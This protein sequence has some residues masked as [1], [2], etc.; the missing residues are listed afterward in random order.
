MKKYLYS[1]AG[2]VLIAF[3]ACVSEAEIDLPNSEPKLVVTS[4][5]SPQDTVILVQISKS[6]PL[7]KKREI[8][9]ENVTVADATVHLSDGENQALLDYDKLRWKYFIDASEF[10]VIAG[11]TYHLKVATPDGLTAEGTC[12]VPLNN[13]TLSF[14][15]EKQI[16][17]RFEKQ[18]YIVTAKWTSTPQDDYG[19]RLF[20]E[21]DFTYEYPPGQSNVSYTPIVI[22]DEYVPSSGTIYEKKGTFTL[23]DEDYDYKNITIGLLNVDEHYYRYHTTLRLYSGDDPFSEPA[24]IYSNIV[25]GLGVFGAYNKTTVVKDFNK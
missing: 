14:D 16:V 18:A 2:L 22:G 4:F 15:Y 20:G 23:F 13:N 25:G 21:A 9:S 11:G 10:P 5:I 12:T 19:F 8:S 1:I 6:A 7:F 3:P 24:P 17:N